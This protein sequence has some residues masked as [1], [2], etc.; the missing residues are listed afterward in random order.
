MEN[1]SK[2]KQ[3]EYKKWRNEKIC[4]G[5]ILEMQREYR[6]REGERC[7]QGGYKKW[8]QKYTERIQKKNIGMNQIYREH[9]GSYTGRSSRGYTEKENDA[10]GMEREKKEVTSD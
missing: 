10:K 6:K 1:G 7:V 3:G 2:S 8:R 4:V 9:T 5:K